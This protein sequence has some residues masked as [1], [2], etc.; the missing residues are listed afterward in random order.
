MLLAKQLKIS[1]QEFCTPVKDM[2]KVFHEG[3]FFSSLINGLHL[4]NEL[5]K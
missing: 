1:F 4:L 2:A 5:I 3:P